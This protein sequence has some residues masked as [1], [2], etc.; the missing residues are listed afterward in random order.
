MMAIFHSEDRLRQKQQRADRAINLAMQNR[1][2]EAAELNREI[3]QD[4]PRDVDAHNRLGKA[5]MELGRYREA[6]DCYAESVSIDAMN[7]IAQKNLA[8]LNKLVE[9]EAAGATELAPT[10]VDPSLFIEET[11]KTTV[12]Q[13]AGVAAADA[14]ARVA[15]GDPVALEVHGN[16]VRALGPGGEL[17][18]RLEPKIGKRVINLIKLGN[19]YTAAVTGVDDQSVRIIIREAHRA[20]SMG[21]RPSFPTAAGDSFRAY[22]RDTVIRYDV[23]EE[24]DDSYDE[25]E[26][27]PELGA[28][29][30]LEVESNLEEPE[31]AEE[32]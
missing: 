3:V 4:F 6:R 27:E 32:P 11:G 24:D 26:T 30:D 16:V 31:F 20:P 19:Q 17:L 8:R 22:T 25:T 21:D 18:G 12:T 28:E 9:E 13:L 14:L 10:P 29:A 2:S 23:D 5:L 1:W 15:A 7:T